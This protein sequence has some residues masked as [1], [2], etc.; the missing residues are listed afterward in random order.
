MYPLA[1]EG[2]GQDDCQK[3]LFSSKLCSTAPSFMLCSYSNCVFLKNNTVR[4]QNTSGRNQAYG[5][6]WKTTFFEI[7][8]CTVMLSHYSPRQE[9]TVQNLLFVSIEQV[10]D[11][12]S[13]YHS[14]QCCYCTFIPPTPH[15]W[16]AAH[17]H[18]LWKLQY[19]HITS[20]H[21]NPM[22][23]LPLNQPSERANT[24]QTSRWCPSSQQFHSVTRCA[25]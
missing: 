25:S 9:I 5:R 14:V 13:H 21:F 3:P 8:L 22:P 7:K 19:E 10:Q 12:P 15:P 2:L 11:T 16:E 6:S 17:F 18:Q 24:P 1:K 23:L 4:K 20:I